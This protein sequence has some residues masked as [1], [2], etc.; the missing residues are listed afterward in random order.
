MEFGDTYFK[1][2]RKIFD[3]GLWR[4]PIVFRLFLWILGH[5]VYDPKGLAYSNVK[6]QRGQYLR[7]YRKLQNDLEY[8]H[9]RQVKQYPLTTIKRAIE[10]LIDFQII[11]KLET[12]LGTLFTIIN[13]DRYQPIRSKNEDYESESTVSKTEL[14]TELKTTC[15]QPANNNKK[16][17]K[18]KKIYSH[19]SVELRLANLLFNLIRENNPQHKEPRIQDWAKSI[20][21]MI[22]IDTRSIEDIESVIR[23]S[24]Q[25]S[26][27][28]K[29][30]L[31]T[32]K[33]REK[34]DQLWLKMNGPTPKPVILP[35]LNNFKILNNNKGINQ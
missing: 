26:F 30:I 23:W 15:E 5:A 10:K 8:V 1:M 4:D 24:Q 6:V 28:H 35:Q 29:N 2:Y 21:L 32:N 11:S 34:F 12:E 3:N 25:D 16:D 7:S 9:N 19:N 22:R 14:G 18:V 27:W 31:S 13:Y 20:D 17:K 33:L